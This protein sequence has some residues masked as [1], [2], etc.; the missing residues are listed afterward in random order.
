MP[1]PLKLVRDE[2]GIMTARLECGREIDEDGSRGKRKP[3]RDG[4]GM[5]KFLKGQYLH[6]GRQGSFTNHLSEGESISKPLISVLHKR[7]AV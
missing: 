6:T 3:T 1:K 2:G 7:M 4:G 5:D